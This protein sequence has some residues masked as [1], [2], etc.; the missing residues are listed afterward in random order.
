MFGSEI[1]VDNHY[2]D[3]VS[4]DISLDDVANT[5]EIDYRALPDARVHERY[6]NIFMPYENVFH[7][8]HSVL[9]SH[10]KVPRFSAAYGW[11]YTN[12]AEGP[13]LEVPDTPLFRRFFSLIS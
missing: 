4:G 12:I 6:A 13:R 9:S 5:I 2:P 1:Y 7:R 10:G 11:S 3:D 8:A